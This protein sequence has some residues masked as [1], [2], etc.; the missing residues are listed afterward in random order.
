M[1]GFNFMKY[2]KIK[3]DDV[4]NILVNVAQDIM[5]PIDVINISNI[6]SLLKTSKYQVKK[7]IDIMVKDNMVELKCEIIHDEYEVIPPYWGYRLTE[8]GKDTKQYKAKQKRHLEIIE[9]C[10]GS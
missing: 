1:G 4:Y 7:Y 9:E 6:A 5:S 2:K 3:Q 10:F 8:K